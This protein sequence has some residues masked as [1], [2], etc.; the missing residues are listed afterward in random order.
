MRDEVLYSLRLWRD[1][2]GPTDWRFGLEDMRTREL[3]HFHRLRDLVRFLEERTTAG[4]GGP[5]DEH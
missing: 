5:Q 3:A 1:G 2:D 4:G